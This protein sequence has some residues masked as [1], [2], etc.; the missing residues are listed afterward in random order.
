[1]KDDK[2]NETYYQPDCLWTGNRRSKSCI[3]SRLY[4]E[5]M[6]I[7][8]YPDKQLWQVYISPPEEIKHP[9]D[10]ATKTSE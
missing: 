8:G 10:K 2:L 4:R 1:M 6:S 3:K 5:R 9:H 7:Y